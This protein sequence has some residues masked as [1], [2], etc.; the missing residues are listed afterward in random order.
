MFQ[1]H[2]VLWKETLGTQLIDRNLHIVTAP[3]QA[4]NAEAN[5]IMFSHH[6]LIQ[7]RQDTIVG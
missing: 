4:L 6:G 1:L 7:K 3:Y 5:N 2:C